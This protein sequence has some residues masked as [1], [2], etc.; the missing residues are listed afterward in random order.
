M[1]PKSQTRQ[2]RKTLSTKPLLL[3]LHR[4]FKKKTQQMQ[5]KLPHKPCQEVPWTFNLEQ[6][7]QIGREEKYEK[8][9]LKKCQEMSQK[10]L[11]VLLGWKPIFDS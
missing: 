10:S 1:A 3:W 11:F 5:I 8:W 2:T 7:E 6:I 4:K 9:F